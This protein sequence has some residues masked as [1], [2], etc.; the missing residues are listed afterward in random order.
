MLL[1]TVLVWTVGCDREPTVPPPPNQPDLVLFLADGLRDGAGSLGTAAQAFRAA[2]AL[3]GRRQYTDA[4]TQSI[5][6][7]VALG[8]LVTGRYPSAI[9][10]C[11]RPRLLDGDT[12]E[13]WCLGIPDPVRTLPEVL[14]YYGYQPAFYSAR[15][16]TH[17]SI[18][19]GF[20]ASGLADTNLEDGGVPALHD[21]ARAWWDAHAD[22][23]RLLVVQVPLALGALVPL[24]Q[25]TDEGALALAWERDRSE[26]IAN[27]DP[28]RYKSAYGGAT[29]GWA[30]VEEAYVATAADAGRAFRALLEDLPAAP[31]RPRWVVTT[32]LQGVSLGDFSGTEH[33]EQIVP[34]RAK[35]LLERTAHVPLD[36]YDPGGTE[37]IVHRPVQLVDLAPT[38]YTL[39]GAVA[40]VGAAGHDLLGPTPP[41]PSAYAEFGDML[42]LRQGPDLITFRAER[43]GTSSLSPTLTEAL[44]HPASAPRPVTWRLSRVT[45][46]PLQREDRSQVDTAT[47]ATLE[48]S[49]IDIRRGIGA[50]PPEALT[51]EHTKQLQEMRAKGYW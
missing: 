35:L 21:A 25:A 36:L 3:D 19:R 16:P 42:L 43:H 7:H 17:P 47:A 11:G 30:A 9:P 14:G 28:A 8:A 5:D 50:P 44:L 2:L 32:S 24:I 12:S 26:P 51:P 34:G 49:L 48:A 38:F 39:A 23:P 46:D 45:T 13:P 10:L 4:Y 22:G 40:P 20:G 37:A 33:P 15:P 1:A 6:P 27:T 31:D 41:T 29:D 18:T